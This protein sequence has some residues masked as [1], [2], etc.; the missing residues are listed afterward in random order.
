METNRKHG[1]NPFVKLDEQ[2]TLASSSERVVRTAQTGRV[3]GFGC[4][5]EEEQASEALANFAKQARENPGAAS[6]P[7]FRQKLHEHV[8]RLEKSIAAAHG[9]QGSPKGGGQ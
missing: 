9:G 5:L 4:S 7:D 1:V 8:E 6:D 3:V 2:V